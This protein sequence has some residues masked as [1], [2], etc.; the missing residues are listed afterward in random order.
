M[1][2]SLFERILGGSALIIGGLLIIIFHKKMNEHRASTTAWLPWFIHWGDL[3]SVIFMLGIIL[4]GIV[5]ILL[6]M[7]VLYGR[8]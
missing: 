5:L 2:E 7:G 3:G 4:F 8:F 1:Q 6:G